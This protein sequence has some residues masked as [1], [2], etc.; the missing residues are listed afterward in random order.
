[1]PDKL[2]IIS[3]KKDIRVRQLLSKN[4]LNEHDM[5]SLECIKFIRIHSKSLVC[6]SRKFQVIPIDGLK[7]AIAID[8][9]HKTDTIFW[10]DVGRSTINRAQLN[11]ENQTQIIQSN[12]I[13]PA[14]LAFDWITDKIYYTDM[15]TN[16]IEVATID[17]RLRTMLIW[18]GIEKPRDIVV[19]PIEGLMF[20]C[21]WGSKP[22]IE[23]ANMDGSE[24][25]VLVSKHLRFPNGLA[26]D[27]SGNRLYFVDSGM[28]TMVSVNSDGSARRTIID[29][30]E[31][32]VHPF[33]IDVYDQK[34]F[35]TDMK[36]LNVESANKNSGKDRQILIANVSDLMDICVF[37]RDRKSI[38]NLCSVS[39]G[40]C[41][42]LCLLNPNGYRCA[43]PI[44]V[45]LSRDGRTC[46]DGPINFIIFARRT[47]IR[48]ISLDNDY[49]VDVVLPLPSMTTVMT[50]DVDSVTG[51]IYW[52]DT[53]EDIIMK[54]TSD[55]IYY[56]KIIGDSLGNVESL[57]VD[58]IG[59]KIYFTDSGRLTVEVAELNGTNRAALIYTDLEA[60]RGIAI[61]YTE[62]LLF[63]TDW[64][65]SR[66]EKAFM[67]GEKRTRIV[68]KDLGWPN[69][70]SIH[71]ER[72]YWTDAKLK[73][74]E[75][76]S[77]EGNHRK[78]ILQ[79]LAHP[80]GLAVTT[81][82]IYY[83]DWKTMS[84]HLIDK[85]NFSAQIVRDNLEG[86][87]DVKFIERE[88][89]SMENVC[90]QNNGNCS[91]LC[92]RNPKGFSCKCPTGIKLQSQTECHALPEVKFT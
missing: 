9:C 67:D 6:I 85:H 42:H 54:S 71:A 48:Q 86:L 8:W 57:V 43:C 18:Q 60:P 33:G 5:V 37:H 1:M 12:L 38:S 59:R 90:G 51:D 28:K 32:L 17:G 36:T 89:K 15:G 80:Y 23:V 19:N 84:L 26:Y 13:S 82:H 41:S 62:G 79:N 11:G 53:A 81:N 77:Y 68:E 87:M 73:K 34:V 69:A 49:L 3:R 35:W 88:R 45:R 14:G 70:L 78:T 21:D 72:I 27:Y 47:D 30:G 31:G 25:K 29:E 7:S 10:T 46:N 63:W 16:R 58:S 24:R 61:D 66:I 22:L 40:G 52:S 74:I 83:S 76:C 55:G 39:N 56:S 44:G 75:S 2:L 92:L 20:W 64:G 65:T 4:S 91:H 50:V